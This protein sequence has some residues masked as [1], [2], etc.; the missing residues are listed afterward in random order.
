[1]KWNRPW[2]CSKMKFN[3]P[4]HLGTGEYL[5][6]WRVTFWEKLT[7]SSYSNNFNRSQIWINNERDGK[8]KREKRKGENFFWGDIFN[9]VEQFQRDV[10]LSN[11]FVKKSMVNKNFRFINVKMCDF[12]II[13]DSTQVSAIRTT[14]QLGR[15]R[16]SYI[17]TIIPSRTWFK[18]ILSLLH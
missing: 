12:N 15:L 1:M 2:I 9:F 11:V 5:T 13:K 7:H 16:I 6:T 8:R 17:A 3:P 4:L 10:K 18:A 14:A